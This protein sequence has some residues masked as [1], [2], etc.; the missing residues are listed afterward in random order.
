MTTT[1]TVANSID[2]TLWPQR[3]GLLAQFTENTFPDVLDTDTPTNFLGSLLMGAELRLDRSP[4]LGT[5]CCGV[6]VG[7]H[8]IL[9]TLETWGA[10]EYYVESEFPSNANDEQSEAATLRY[11]FDNIAF[12]ACEVYMIADALNISIVLAPM[13]GYFGVFTYTPG[14]K[15]KGCLNLSATVQNGWVIDTWTPIND[16]AS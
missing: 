5:L 11:D 6:P 15:I 8:E 7:V 14:G 4:Y 12:K 16:G 2:L 1:T 13:D 10:D 3:L 9:S